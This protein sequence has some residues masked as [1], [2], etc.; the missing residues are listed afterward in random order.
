MNAQR[1]V[2]YSD[3]CPLGDISKRGS[4][5]VTLLALQAFR[6][7]ATAIRT[8]S[9]RTVEPIWTTPRASILPSWTREDECASTV[10]QPSLPADP[11]NGSAPICAASADGEAAKPTIRHAPRAASSA[12]THCSGRSIGWRSKSPNYGKF[13]WHY[14]R[15][16]QPVNALNPE[17]TNPLQGPDLYGWVATFQTYLRSPPPEPARAAT[18]SG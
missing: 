7:N 1:H 2:G 16:S 4:I 14:A 12:L 18:A 9:P 10:L 15:C 11:T 17:S 6:L 5:T 8:H 3:R 13:T